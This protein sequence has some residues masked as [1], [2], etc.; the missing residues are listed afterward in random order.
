M[1][2]T[3]MLRTFSFAALDRNTAVSRP[4]GTPMSAAPNVPYTLDKINDNMPNF[5]SAAVE[6]HWVPNKKRNR[7]ILWMAGTPE[8]TI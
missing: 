6:A 3:T 7:P 8:T 1:A 5:G 2:V 4:T